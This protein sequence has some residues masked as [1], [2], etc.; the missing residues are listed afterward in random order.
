MLPAPDKQPWERLMQAL[1]DGEMDGPQFQDEF[2]AASRDATARG[3]R[4]PYAADLMFYEVDAYCADPALRGENDLDEAGL[5][6]AARR[7]IT[8]LDE[9]W[10]KLPRT[11]SDEQILE[12]F[13]RAADRLLR[14]GK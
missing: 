8:R 10:P 3:E 11:P 1:L 2:L 14:R 12:N 7:L 5:R 13:R 9:P 6:D 4:V